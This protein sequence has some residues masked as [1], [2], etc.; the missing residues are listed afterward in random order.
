MSKSY[1]II[2]LSGDAPDS[3]Q[4]MRFFDKSSADK[5]FQRVL[6]FLGWQHA[7]GEKPTLIIQNGPRTGKHDP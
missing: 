6:Y 5:L 3:Q 4:R 1:V 2:M 7:L